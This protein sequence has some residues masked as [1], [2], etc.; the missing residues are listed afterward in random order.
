MADPV[1]RRRVS[2]LPGLPV[3]VAAPLSKERGNGK[4]KIV[5]PTRF[6]A[7][8]PVRIGGIFG[9]AQERVFSTGLHLVAVLV[10]SVTVIQ[11]GNL[12]LSAWS[13]YWLNQAQAHS[14]GV[15]SSRAGRSTTGRR[16]GYASR[17]TPA[18]G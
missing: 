10:P 12:S 1:A 6:Y 9:Y 17:R 13:D 11:R 5:T 18:R 15:R 7:G 8:V 2:A 3:D 4:G 16:R 14:G